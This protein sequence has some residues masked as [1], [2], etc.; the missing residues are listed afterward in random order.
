MEKL[1]PIYYHHKNGDTYPGT[2]FYATKNG[3]AKIC[4]NALDNP[5]K[6]AYV[7]KASI[8]SQTQND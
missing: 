2:F 1:T 8:T 4:Y 3:R 5:R 7:S 6:I